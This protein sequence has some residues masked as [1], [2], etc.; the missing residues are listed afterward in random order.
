MQI[1][2]ETDTHI[3]G[4]E[5]FSRWASS[6]IQANLARFGDQ[7]TRVQAHFSDE[8]A[9]KKDTGRQHPVHAGS[10]PGG[11]SADGPETQRSQFE[12]SRGGRFREDGTIAGQHAGQIRLDL[13]VGLKG[14]Q[15]G[16][17]GRPLRAL[18]GYIFSTLSPTGRSPLPV[19]NWK[20]MNSQVIWLRPGARGAVAIALALG[21]AAADAQPRYD[22]D[23]YRPRYGDAE[24][25]PLFRPGTGLPLRAARGRRSAQCSPGR[26]GWCRIRWRCGRGPSCPARRP[27]R[28][29]T[30]RGCKRR[31]QR[32]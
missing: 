9:G 26:C 30:G 21:A 13:K 24:D 15:N 12:T 22:G 2:I 25:C 8:N 10:A 20:A 27:G 7:I 3:D 19:M 4:N 31:P 32:G 18:R 16:Q 23:R 14:A 5:A 29:R 11:S 17:A 28:R 6:E 1:L